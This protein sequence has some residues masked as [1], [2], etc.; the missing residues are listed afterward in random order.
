MTDAKRDGNFVPVLVG[1][2]SDDGITILPFKVD[3]ITGRLLCK[4]N[5][6]SPAHNKVP[7]PLRGVKK[8]SNNVSVL[9]GELSDNSGVGPFL[10]GGN[11]LM[12]Q[13][14]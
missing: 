2:S 4:R 10:I 3:S 12:M 13:A 11:N 9:A 5:A 6:V 8:D 14:N 7:D 1:V